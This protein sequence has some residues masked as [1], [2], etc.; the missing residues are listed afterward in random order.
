M[1]TRRMAGLAG[2]LNNYK[3]ELNNKKHL[4]VLLVA[5]LWVGL[6]Q[7]FSGLYE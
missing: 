6:I 1:V 5:K 7:S 3:K 2:R 4:A